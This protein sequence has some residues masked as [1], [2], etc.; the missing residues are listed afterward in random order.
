MRRSN[1]LRACGWLALLAPLVVTATPPE[2][3]PYHSYRVWGKILKPGGE[4]MVNAAVALA[5]NCGE[6]GE[7]RLLRRGEGDCACTRED[8]GNA[9]ALTDGA[10]SF[11]LN[12]ATCQGLDSLAVAVVQTD[13]FVMGE[14]FAAKDATSSYRVEDTRAHE[15]DGFLCIT[16]TGYTT[17]VVGYSNS[18]PPDTLVV[19]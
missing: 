16:S 2:I 9:V 13:R 18:Y 12:V 17:V 5:T 7:Y 11:Y 3:P 1:A 8:I 10:G 15:E 4:P 19:E 6:N 14:P